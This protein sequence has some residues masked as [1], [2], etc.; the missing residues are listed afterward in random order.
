MMID[1]TK[2]LTENSDLHAGAVLKHKTLGIVRVVR[3]VRPDFVEFVDG[4]FTGRYC[5]C[6]YLR[7]DW[8]EA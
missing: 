2:S 4:G 1:A 5:L 8:R 3:S 7:A 6:D